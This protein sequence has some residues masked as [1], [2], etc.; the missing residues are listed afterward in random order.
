MRCLYALVVYIV[1]VT[2]VCNDNK[3][4]LFSIFVYLQL[5]HQL[6]LRGPDIVNIY[7]TA[8]C[9]SIN[10]LYHDVCTITVYFG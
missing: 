5:F 9:L 7:Y 6:R 4:I 2:S 1:S 3:S 10:R 8:I